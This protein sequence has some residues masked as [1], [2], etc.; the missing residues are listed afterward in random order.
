MP[1][2]TM[3]LRLEIYSEEG[4]TPVIAVDN[5]TREI[6]VDLIESRIFEEDVNES[7]QLQTDTCIKLTS[8]TEDTAEFEVVAGYSSPCLKNKDNRHA[9]DN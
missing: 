3:E 9:V 2:S 8:N 4:W 7:M 6:I 5:F 1:T